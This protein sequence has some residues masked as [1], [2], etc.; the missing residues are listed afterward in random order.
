MFLESCLQDSQENTCV[1]DSILIKLQ[2]Q[3]CKKETLVQVFSCEFCEISKNTFS[4]DW[5]TASAFIFSEAATGDFL[6]KNVFLEI[7]QNSQEN[8]EQ[9]FTEH[10]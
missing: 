6:W 8:T 5:K 2:A 1:R 9:Q 3:G 7:P 4:T 10:L